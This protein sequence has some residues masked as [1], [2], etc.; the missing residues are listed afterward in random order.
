MTQTTWIIGGG[1]VVLLLAFALYYMSG[2]GSTKNAIVLPPKS[3][4]QQ[5]STASNTTVTNTP[6]EITPPHVVSPVTTPPEPQSKSAPKT[7][8][9]M[10]IL[11]T[12][13]GDITLKLYDV[14]SPKTVANFIKLAKSGFYNGVRFHRVIKDFMIQS[15]DPLSKDDSKQE[16]WGTGGPGYAFA[17]EFN[18]HK[19][20]RGSL[21]MANS[22]PNTNGSQFFIVTK[23]ATPWLDGVH[24]NF[25]EVVAGMDVVMKIQEVPTLPGD[26][27][28]TPVTITSVVVK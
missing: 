7:G 12:T 19:L 23:F 18:A 17:D 15:G 11:K 3:D 9:T 13:M 6:P 4:I 2:E 20:V 22:G 25:G 28:E 14:D 1:I 8:A 24:T 27:P 16:M 21:A 10:V 5:S 26:R